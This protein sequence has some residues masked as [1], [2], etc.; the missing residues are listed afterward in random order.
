MC[1]SLDMHMIRIGYFYSTA[2][3]KLCVLIRTYLDKYISYWLCS[4][5]ACCVGFTQYIT[6]MQGYERGV[7]PVFRPG[8]G[9]LRRGL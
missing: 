8:I 5:I 3:E 9:E 7:Q 4:N 2:R 6:I 1:L